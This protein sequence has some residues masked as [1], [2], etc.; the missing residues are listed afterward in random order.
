VQYLDNDGDERKKKLSKVLFKARGKCC[1]ETCVENTDVE[2]EICSNNFV[3]A[4]KGVYK[5][6]LGLGGSSRIVGK[7]TKVYSLGSISHRLLFL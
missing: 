3:Q 7:L 4:V 1:G 6:H 5:K 2:R